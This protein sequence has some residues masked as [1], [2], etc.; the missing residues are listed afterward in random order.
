MLNEYYCISHISLF[1][2]SMQHPNDDG[3]VKFL[4]GKK[5]SLNWIRWNSFDFFSH[6]S[7]LAHSLSPH[8]DI[9]PQKLLCFLITKAKNM[10]CVAH[11]LF[12][13]NW[14]KEEKGINENRSEYSLWSH[15]ILSI[16]SFFHFSQLEWDVCIFYFI[17][18]LL[19]LFDFIG[20]VALL[21]FV[22]K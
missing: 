20:G 21:F 13:F 9:Q 10:I 2:E 6:L 15:A 16:F 5:Y 3:M 4:L 11:P 12:K 14:R 18:S 22:K 1:S 8:T 19:C 7:F 17:L